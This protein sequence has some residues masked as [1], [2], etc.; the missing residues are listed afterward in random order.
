MMNCL[1][2]AIVSILKKNNL[3]GEV[4]NAAEALFHILD[5]VTASNDSSLIMEEFYTA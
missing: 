4:F 3:K 5:T 1:T 2:S